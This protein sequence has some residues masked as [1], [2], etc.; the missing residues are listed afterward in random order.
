M[1][2]QVA[3]TKTH[4]VTAATFNPREVLGVVLPMV[5]ISASCCMAFFKFYIF[6]FEDE[7]PFPNQ[8]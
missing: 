3:E 6:D 1:E 7:L 5:F 4:P 2:R 8:S